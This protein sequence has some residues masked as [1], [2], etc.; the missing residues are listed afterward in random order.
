MSQSVFSGGNRFRSVRGLKRFFRRVEEKRALLNIVVSVTRSCQS[1]KADRLEAS[2]KQTPPA[3]FT[4]R[5]CWPETSL[6]LAIVALVC[7]FFG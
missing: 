5:Q 3:G 2:G 4:T 7:V 1:L 6:R